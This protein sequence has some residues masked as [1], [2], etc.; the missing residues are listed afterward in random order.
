MD[1]TFIPGQDSPWRVISADSPQPEESWSPNAPNKR[2]AP[3]VAPTA[4]A[5]APPPTVAHLDSVLPAAPPADPCVTQAPAD[6]SPAGTGD[7]DFL[8][9]LPPGS[10][11]HCSD[12]PL[13]IEARLQAHYYRSLF[14]RAKQREAAKDA[15]IAQL[16]ADLRILKQ[17]LYGQKSESRHGADQPRT[18]THQD[19]QDP[20]AED[21]R[22]DEGAKPATP[23]PAAAGSRRKRGQQKGNPVPK[24]RDY[25]HL[26][27]LTDEYFLSDCEARCSCC[28]KPF[29]PGG[30]EKD[31]E[32]IEIQVK[33]YRNRIRRK[34]YLRTCS[35]PGLPTVFAAPVVPRVLPHCRL[36]ISVWVQI[37]L[38]KYNYCRATHK[39]LDD[40]GSHGLGL[41][42]GTII[43]NFKRLAPLFEPVYDKLKERN[44][45]L[46]LWHADETR[47]PVFQVISGKVGKRWYVWLFESA[48]CCVFT[49]DKGRAH[50][51]PEDHFGPKARGIVV[52]DR[53]SAYKAMKHV[54]EGRLRLA[55]CWAHQRRDF[56]DVEKSWPKLSDWAVGWL[57][58]IG[59]LY[60]RNDERLQEKAG[61]RAFQ[62][63]DKE[64]RQALEKMHE[65]MAGQLK[66]EK[67][68]PAKRKVLQS[69]QEHWEGLTLFVDNP[70]VPMDN[71]QGERTLR[72]VALCRKN[73][74]GSGSEWSGKLAMSMFSIVATLKKQGI[75]PRKWLTAYLQ[76]CA[77]A[78]G[79]APENVDKWLP[80]N[81][82]AQQKKDMVAQQEDE[83]GEASDQQ[84]YAG[85]EKQESRQAAT[86]QDRK[87]RS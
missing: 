15:R 71:N 10:C 52:V 69:M 8:N 31:T 77:Q 9:P 45:Q 22:P 79:K 16:E 70:Q 26:P 14:Q 48:D 86:G 59:A 37:L 81:L 65:S 46:E 74:Y 54:K 25:S 64:L 34:R 40:L 39:Q 73:Y 19:T 18:P 83:Q 67:L 29:S 27:V 60:Q 51:V 42:S 80:W 24:R 23:A 38:D 62:R 53:Y 41:A 3:G 1:L 21:A 72:I 4:Q 78:G 2:I 30:Y 33:A 75:N 44:R 68:H 43:G 56:L 85:E 13:L 50:D 7:P 6:S 47:W 11:P 63:K 61:S 5:D 28:G 58:R 12:R 20:L 17:R 36:G 76:A 87:A 55:F 35:C 84:E 49:L 32:I 66:E 82:S 57:G